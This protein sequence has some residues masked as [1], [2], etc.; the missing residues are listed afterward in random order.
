MT[1]P[2]AVPRAAVRPVSLYFERVGAEMR[3][4]SSEGDRQVTAAFSST[5]VQGAAHGR[6]FR[7]P[8]S[9]AGRLLPKTQ[10]CG[11]ALARRRKSGEAGDYGLASGRLCMYNAAFRAF[12]CV[13]PDRSARCLIWSWSGVR[14]E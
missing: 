14:V 11:G 6:R 5:Y 8:A 12:A 7:H 10:L 2:G 13:R 4:D 1:F 3:Y 9:P